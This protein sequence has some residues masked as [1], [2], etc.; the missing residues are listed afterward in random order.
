MWSEGEG[1]EEGLGEWMEGWKGSR[2]RG[3]REPGESV[4]G[5]GVGRESMV[6]SE[7]QREGN[8]ERN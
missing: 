3:I 7:R 6:E 1:E 4:E 8:G 5:N 2:G